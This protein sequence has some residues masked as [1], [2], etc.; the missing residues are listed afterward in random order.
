MI[1]V[2]GWQEEEREDVHRLGVRQVPSQVKDVL[3]EVQRRRGARRV[4]VRVVVVP[5]LV[6][7]PTRVPCDVPEAKFC[8]QKK[9]V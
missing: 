7:G 8:G 5:E 3:Q 9:L 2:W 4:E 1:E 6:R